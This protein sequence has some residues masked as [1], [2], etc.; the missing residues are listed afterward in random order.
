MAGEAL[1]TIA[2]ELFVIVTLFAIVVAAVLF[3]SARVA[4]GFRLPPILRL[5]PIAS[6][7]GRVPVAGHERPA[8][9]ASIGTER[10]R[11][12]AVASMM[13]SMNRR[14]RLVASGE[15]GDW[16]A[17]H[18]RHLAPVSA[19]PETGRHSAPVGRSFRR[20]ARARVSASANRRD[21]S[22]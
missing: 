21:S 10:S 18:D 1:P 22:A 2:T 5:V 13:V 4:K 3:A 9:G 16:V 20:Q 19:R 15:G 14:E 17:R 12:A 11:A 8:T 6:Q 7:S